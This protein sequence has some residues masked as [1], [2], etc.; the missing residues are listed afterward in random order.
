[1]A[2]KGSASGH[3][4][5]LVEA[6]TPAVQSARGLPGN[7]LDNAVKANIRSGVER[8]KSSTPVLAGL[9]MEG[10]LKIVGAHYGLRDGAVDIIV[11]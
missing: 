6:L 1:M 4:R 5:S 10:N 11:A 8:L 2:V 9:A 7:L 3:I